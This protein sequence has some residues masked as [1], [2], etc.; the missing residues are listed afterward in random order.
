MTIGEVLG[1][2]PLSW[3]FLGVK[4]PLRVRPQKLETFWKGERQEKELEFGYLFYF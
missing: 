4:P 1:A 2:L 3:A